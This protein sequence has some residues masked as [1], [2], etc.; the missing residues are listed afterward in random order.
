[1]KKHTDSD[2]LEIINNFQKSLSKKPSAT[3]MF[4]EIKMMKFKVRRIQGNLSEVNLNNF[5]FVS[6]LWSLGKLDEFFQKEYYRLTEKKQNLFIKIFN[7]IYEKFQ[8]D[9]NRI[10]LQRERNSRKVHSLEVEIFK[11][12]KDKLEN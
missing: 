3:K 1:M 5:E 9:L 6:I 10:N 8:Q 2:V 11:E 7:E 4:Q 12:I